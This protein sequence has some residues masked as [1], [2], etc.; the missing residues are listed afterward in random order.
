MPT[1]SLD[2]MLGKTGRPPQAAGWCVIVPLHVATGLALK[3][4]AAAGR[5]WLVPGAPQSPASPSGPGASP[6]PGVG[7][8]I[9]VAGRALASHTRQHHC[10]PTALLP[11]SGALQAQLHVLSDFIVKLLQGDCGKCLISWNRRI[12][13]NG[14]I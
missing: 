6:Q 12:G 7:L 2:V 9:S 13:R 4:I 11:C 8:H 14:R 5:L 10:G 1:D 3:E